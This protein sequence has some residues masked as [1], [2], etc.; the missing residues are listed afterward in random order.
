MKDKEKSKNM[1]L[2]PS[3]SHHDFASIDLGS[4][5]KQVLKH[6]LSE[7]WH[8]KNYEINS[9]VVDEVISIRFLKEEVVHHYEED[10]PEICEESQYSWPSLD[11]R[12]KI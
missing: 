2:S 4:P 1:I 11:T 5:N 8:N 10:H 7:S 12:E 6:I 9:K 3:P